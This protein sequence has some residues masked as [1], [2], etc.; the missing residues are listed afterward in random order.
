MQL[1][2]PPINRRLSVLG[3]EQSVG[4]RPQCI[5]H[6][7]VHHADNAACDAVVVSAINPRIKEKDSDSDLVTDNGN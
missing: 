4:G 3:G 7:F 6:L 1:F 5:G 2:R